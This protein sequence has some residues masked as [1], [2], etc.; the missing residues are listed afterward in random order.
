[1]TDRP[2]LQRGD[3]VPHFEVKTIGGELFSYSAIWQRRHLVLLTVQASG[4]EAA[5]SEAAE[6]YISELMA[7]RSEF[8]AKDA[9]CVVTGDRVPGIHSPAV[10]VADRWG[11]IVH[12]AIASKAYVRSVPQTGD[13]LASARSARADVY[14]ISIVPAAAHL[15]ATRHGEALEKVRELAHGL[16]VDGWFTCNHTH[17][18]RVASFRERSEYGTGGAR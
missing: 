7:R 12:I 8:T 14:T 3:S 18:A 11:E 15:S 5:E 10:V 17:Y 6:T 13:V 1:M 2:M 4:S 9:E 16:D